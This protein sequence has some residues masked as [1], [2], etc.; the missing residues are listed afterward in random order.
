MGI[1]IVAYFINQTSTSKYGS[2]LDGIDAFDTTE[3][4][5]KIDES[6]TDESVISKDIHITGKIIYIDLSVSETTT[7]EEIQNICTSTLSAI[8]DE[9]KEYFDIQYIV[10]RD[11][12]SPYM[13]SKNHI[14]QTITWGN[15]SFDVTTTTTTKNKK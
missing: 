8:S 15:Y 11:G 1:G 5:N 2:R 12:L 10:E 14:K 7:N 3:I 13:G 4:V 9:A 6:I